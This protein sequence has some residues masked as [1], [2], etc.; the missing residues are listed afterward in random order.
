MTDQDDRADDSDATWSGLGSDAGVDE[1][2]SELDAARDKTLRVTAELENYRKRASRELETERRYAAQPLLRD[3]L[4]VLDNVQRA[5]DSAGAAGSGA[6]LLEGVKL[7]AQQL[8]AILQRHHCTRIEAL[9]HPFDP[10]LHEAISQV[11]TADHPPGMVI[12]E[13]APGYLLHD[14]VIRPAQVVVSAAPQE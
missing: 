11:R 13:A 1:L 10:H 7:V 2:R 12:V 3:L 4:P 6:G 8:H 5:I 9:G 14:R